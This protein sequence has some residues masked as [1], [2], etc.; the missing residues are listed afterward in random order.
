PQA[1][2]ANRRFGILPWRRAASAPPDFEPVMVD[3]MP[4]VRSLARSRA[5]DRFG[6]LVSAREGW[7]KSEFPR[8]IKRSTIRFALQG[9]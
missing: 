2:R 6:G 8:R 7:P 5:F 1:D 4:R 9:L 3:R